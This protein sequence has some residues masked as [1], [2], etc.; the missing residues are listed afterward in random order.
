KVPYDIVLEM[1]EINDDFPSTDV[2]IVISREKLSFHTLRHTYASW[3]VMAGVPPYVVGKALGHKTLVM[4][5]RYAHLAPDSHRIV[6]EAV[7]K[8]HNGGKTIDGTASMGTT[9]QE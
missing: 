7:A 6:F 1:D 3:A 4:T 9:E 2:V 8:N 5:Q